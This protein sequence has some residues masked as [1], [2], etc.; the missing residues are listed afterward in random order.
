MSAACREAA[1]LG[2][3]ADEMERTRIEAGEHRQAR[4]AVL[5]LAQRHE[6]IAFRFA[7]ASHE[8]AIA[9]RLRHQE[10]GM[11]R[12]ALDLLTQSVDVRFQCL[13]RHVRIIAP[14]LP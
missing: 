8:K 14:N 1:A 10:L 13:G 3:T 4:Q 7:A 12:V 11:G 9:A 6:V 2:R 5:V